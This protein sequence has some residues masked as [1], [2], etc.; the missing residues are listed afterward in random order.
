MA[1]LKLTS[2]LKDVPVKRTDEERLGLRTHADALS[3]FI[4]Q[5]DTPITIGIQGDW[6]VGKTSLLNMVAENLTRR[7]N[8]YKTIKIE[9]WQ[10]AQLGE[11]TLTFA[12]LEAIN[13]AVI[14]QIRDLA[15]KKEFQEKSKKI[16]GKL[17]KA[18]GIAASNIIKEKLGVD[19]DQ[20][21]EVL[22]EGEALE[23]SQENLAAELERLKEEFRSVVR[24]A[25]GEDEGK[26]VIMLDD[27]DRIKPVKA[28]ELLEAIKNFLDVNHTVFILA[29]DYSVIRQGVKE[30]FGR[31]SK[32]FYGKSFFDKIIQVP[33]NMPVSAYTVEDYIMG[34]M[35]WEKSENDPRFYTKSESYSEFGYLSGTKRQY[36]PAEDAEF[37]V[38]I[39]K[40]ATNNNPR[41]IKRILNYANLLRIIYRKNKYSDES[42][43]FKQKLWSLR[44]AKIVMAVAAMHL[45]WPEVLHYF[46]Q[47]PTPGVLES[48]KNPSTLEQLPEIKPLLNRVPDPH[49]TIAQISGLIDLLISVIDE[50]SDGAITPVEFKPLWE[51]LTKANLTNVRLANPAEDLFEFLEVAKQRAKNPDAYG[52]LKKLHEAFIHSRWNNPV[53]LRFL[54]AGKYTRHIEWDKEIVGSMV[55]K[56][57]SPIEIYLSS[58]ALGWEKPESAEDYPIS[59]NLKP[60]IMPFPYP[61][62]GL[63]DLKLNIRNLLSLTP[64]R[65]SAVFNL[66][67]NEIKKA[68]KP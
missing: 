6:G 43:G 40:L 38:Q 59:E 24:E 57:T 21:K 65:Q 14:H 33:F 37:F 60:Y 44:E 9:T 17:G 20:L 39:M 30:K 22:S 5:C 2:L 31:D 29:V 66:I 54:E 18:L 8:K 23:E 35:G 7:S 64:E 48:L 53:L 47:Q 19:T 51:V 46:A 67:L 28:L 16:F 15:K 13:R 34:L 49:K 1:N 56:V 58:A 32:E 12:V 26:I 42:R 63:G 36:I 62:Q 11:E 50:N 61:H 10:Y 25:V 3:E 52:D 45:A 27:L 4:A 55:T 41:S 68:G